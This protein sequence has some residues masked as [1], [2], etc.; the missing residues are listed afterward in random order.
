MVYPVV[1]EGGTW[2]S[3]T[4]FDKDALRV[5]LH[6]NDTMVITMQRDNQNIKR[7]L[8]D[9]ESF[10]DVLLWDVSEASTQS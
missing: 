1:N 3:I 6:D 7:V 5:N 8:I 10:A 2:V 9:L 4:F